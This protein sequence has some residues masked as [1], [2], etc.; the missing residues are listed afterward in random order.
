MISINQLKELS[1]HTDFK[2]KATNL[3][4]ARTDN[5][6]NCFKKIG[7]K[8]VGGSLKAQTF[9]VWSCSTFLSTSIYNKVPQLHTTKL[10]ASYTRLAVKSTHCTSYALSTLKLRLHQIMITKLILVRSAKFTTHFKNPFRSK[11]FN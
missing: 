10:C 9:V 4:Y 8:K 11:N 5:P 1:F 2:S 6:L 3:V 7:N